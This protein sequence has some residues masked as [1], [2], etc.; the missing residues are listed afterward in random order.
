MLVDTAG[1]RP[2]RLAE[3]WERKS[4]GGGDGFGDTVSRQGWI[5]GDPRMEGLGLDAAGGELGSRSIAVIAFDPFEQGFA[6]RGRYGFGLT[7]RHA[8]PFVPTARRYSVTWTPPTTPASTISAL[9][10][11]G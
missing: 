7:A 10:I 4:L 1:D 8:Q 11:A 9:T 6:G 3:R 2:A 5:G